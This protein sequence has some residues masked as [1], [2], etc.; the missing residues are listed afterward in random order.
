MTAVLLSLIASENTWAL[1][2]IIAAW[3]AV[4][5][6]LEQRYR[7]AR[8][9]SGPVLLLGGALVLSTARVIPTQ[10]PVYDVVW[11]Y[12]VP[13]CVPL[14]LFRANV[15][16]IVRESGP[17][18]LAFHIAAIGTVAGAFVAFL[19]LRH[20]GLSELIVLLGIMTGSYTGG[21]VNFLALTDRYD[22]PESLA[23]ALLVAD[24]VV[25]AVLFLVCFSLTS[26]PFL[27][28][29]FRTPH[30]D[31]VDR[32]GDDA[33]AAS[34]YW[35]PKPISLRDIALALAIAVAIAGIANLAASAVNASSAPD[36]IKAV[37]GQ[38][39]LVITILCVLV[40]TT[41]DRWLTRIQGADELGT[42]LIYLFF[43][44]LGA[45]AD[46]VT[47]VVKAPILLVLCAI[48]AITNLLVTLGLSWIL[49][50]PLEEAALAVN[51]TLG[52]AP[53]AAAMA[54]AKGWTSLVVPSI[55]VGIW[56]YIVGTWLGAAV[57]RMLGG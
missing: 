2:A 40:A 31:E 7:W 42:Y 23:N 10:S 36:W 1:W 4:S 39:Y 46:F 25:M 6:T 38:S 28:R 11:D 26:V 56:G 41:C 30:A 19:A 34:D 32:A 49:R 33:T 9:I 20:S 15:V 13:V 17:M 18:F 43:F 47:V 35:K 50:R 29:A 55:L 54:I 22:P 21:S 3:V 5:I 16:R 45:P 53:S 14:L 8:V 52:G 24:N 44:V 51:V 12:V 48:M 37:L 57:I 27:R